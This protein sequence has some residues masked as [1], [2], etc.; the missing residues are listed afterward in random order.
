MLV[1]ASDSGGGGKFGGHSEGASAFC[2]AVHGKRRATSGAETLCSGQP[3][4]Q[5]GAAGACAYCREKG[6]YCS[7]C[8]ELTADLNAQQVRI[9]QGE[10]YFPGSREKIDGIPCDMERV[11]GP[12][13][14]SQA[15]LEATLS[16]KVVVGTEWQ[17]PVVGAKVLEI[18]SNEQVMFG[19]LDQMNFNFPKKIK[20]KEA[21]GPSAAG[22]GKKKAA[23][24]AKH[25]SGESQSHSESRSW[26]L[27]CQ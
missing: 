27:S 13:G 16:S 14:P 17:P 1:G 3:P 4:N 18:Q 2:S 21:A 15:K 9:W 11:A 24:L 5:G 23:K 7:Q 19:R 12:H 20:G 22:L 26:R 10:I 6:H 25:L 8:V